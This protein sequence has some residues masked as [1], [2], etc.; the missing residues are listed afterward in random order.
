MQ[1]SRRN[2]L[3]GTSL[4]AASASVAGYKDMLSTAATMGRKGRTPN[5]TIY[6]DAQ[7][8]E[9]VIHTSF[10]KNSDFS[11]RNGVCNGCTSHCGM[12]VKIENKSGKIVKATGNPY[13]LLSTD[14]WLPYE[15][16]LK[17]SFTLLGKNSA[18][19]H[20]YRSTACARGNVVFDRHYDKGR[21]LTPL[22][23]VGKRGEDKWQSISPEQ[24]LKEI[25]EGGNLFGEGE[26]KG[27]AAIRDLETPMDPNDP[28]CGPK[29]NGLCVLGT[30][31]EGRQAYMVNRFVASFGTKNYMGHTAI[32]GLSMR[33][34]EAVYLGD[35]KGYPHLKPDF[36]HCEYLLS[37]GT[38]PAQAGNP[39]KRQAKLLAKART[40]GK[41][42]CVTVAPMLTNSDALA[43][44]GMSEWIP[45]NP[46]GD[47]AFV[48]GLLRVIIEE[49]LYNE[50]YLKLPSQE[51]QVAANDA[52]WTNATHLVIQTDEKWGTVVKEGEEALVFDEESGQ[53]SP[54]SK[55]KQAKL[56][57]DEIIELNGEQVLVKSA[58]TLLKESA[59]K[60]SLEEYSKESGVAVERI[61]KTA[62]EF[63]SHG[64][65]AAIDCHGGTMHTTGFYT[66]Y[67]I[68]MLGA[69]VGNLNYQ[70]GM[71]AGGG[72]YKDFNGARYNLLAYPGKVETKGYRIDRARFAYEN[73]TEY[74]QKVA[75][76][77]NPY[78][79]KDMWY[80]ITNALES[81]VIFN[82]AKAYPYKLDAVIS[83][84]ANF[85]YGQ[86]GSEALVELLKEPKK[87][88]PL[89]I[90][91]DPFI[92]E[93]SRFADYIVPDSVMYETWGVVS[94]WAASQ[95]KAN[96]LRYPTVEAPQSR[97]AN[98]EPV[99]MDSFVIELGKR[100]GLPGFGDNAI[101]GNDGKMYPFHRPQ[102]FYV[103]VME[104]V[105]LDAGGVLDCSDEEIELAGL[106]PFVPMLKEICQE[107][108]RK[109]AYIMARG[110]RFENKE[111]GY[112]DGKLAHPYKKPVQV[113]FEPLGKAKNALTGERYSGVPIFTQARLARGEKLAVLYPKS[114]YPLSAFSY[115]SNVISQ[116]T[117][118]SQM[119]KEIRPTT[120]IDLNPITAKE[121]GV[122]H[123]QKIR[124]VSP[125]NAIEGRVRLRQGVLPGTVGLE[126]GAG[127]DGEGALDIWI[128]GQKIQG[129]PLRKSGVNINKLGLLD[130]S[131]ELAT[132]SD[133]VIG[134]NAR[135]ALPA[136]IEIL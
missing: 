33:S 112:K 23:R 128:D 106:E 122:A 24:L 50:N 110:G 92:N 81:E 53:L 64:R 133:F 42:K 51:A 70:G 45:I 100:L 102:D 57:V 28:K 109:V 114:Q 8:T 38:S 135:Q 62:R 77:K 58:M 44:G 85:I 105:A 72:K 36:E 46:G 47:L 71:S 61:I 43:A 18:Q 111:K 96:T 123:G 107:N 97:F 127:R 15:T 30:A 87:A 16:P 76:G 103:R 48:M 11:I 130:N 14:P 54:A 35:I 83:W 27:L 104:N 74:A 136:R 78:P 29:A 4:V 68:M 52:S 3:I 1:T 91:I 19:G 101:K 126:H 60:F 21:V 129:C 6:A 117:T 75:Q 82:S 17:E 20:E 79:A 93:T 115:K 55:V 66:T 34:G 12:R 7:K 120:Y 84:N 132:L 116:A 49:N 131:R 37:I 124:L 119:I 67:S 86:S 73:T 2:F 88:V 90:A 121:Q 99:S 98:G 10:D 39:F 63:A 32:C 40:Y 69:M 65:K 95:T 89:F 26:V 118:S 41:L 59:M 94:P 113:Y 13:N 5:D 31:N 134:S 9:G 25:T 108:W 80:P 56:F 22:K 125:S